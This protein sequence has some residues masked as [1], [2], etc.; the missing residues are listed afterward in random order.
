ML[1]IEK[2]EEGKSCENKRSIG[3]KSPKKF[4]YK[5]QTPDGLLPFAKH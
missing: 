1:L 5:K 3:G 4:Q 2:R